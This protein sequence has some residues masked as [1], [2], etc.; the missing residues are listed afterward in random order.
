MPKHVVVS[1]TVIK[2]TSVTQ[3]CL[4]TYYF[5][6]FHTHTH[7]TGMTHFQDLCNSV[8]CAPDFRELHF[9]TAELTCWGP[10]EQTTLQR[11]C[12]TLTV[13]K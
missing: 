1:I 4:T 12:S 6:K 8:S 9:D 13:L 7:T 5:S 2:Y 3:L 11:D 10:T